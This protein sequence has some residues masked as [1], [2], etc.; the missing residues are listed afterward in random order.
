MTFPCGHVFWCFLCCN[1]SYFLHPR[2]EKFLFLYQLYLFF[3]SPP[4]QSRK[5]YPI[6]MPLSKPGRDFQLVNSATILISASLA[7][8]CFTH[9]MIH[10]L[11]LHFYYLS[12]PSFQPSV[13]LLHNSAFTLIYLY[14]FFTSLQNRAL[15]N[16]DHARKI[17]LVRYLMSSYVHGKVLDTLSEHAN[18][19]ASSAMASL[20]DEADQLSHFPFLPMPCDLV[21]TVPRHH[22]WYRK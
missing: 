21:L 13:I 20:E 9:L 10:V 8:I 22:G 12:L 5:Y 2:G 4:T 17:E 18:A 19:L 6:P 14:S 15:E 16:T 3:H 7:F 11:Q 1:N